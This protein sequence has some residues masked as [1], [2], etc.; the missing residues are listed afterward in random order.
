MPQMR[1]NLYLSF[2]LFVKVIPL[3]LFLAHLFDGNYI[4]WLFLSGREYNT[5]FATAKLLNYFKVLTMPIRALVIEKPQ[6]T[7]SAL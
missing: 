5:K 2:D 1:L 4:T 6:T 7:A 3:E